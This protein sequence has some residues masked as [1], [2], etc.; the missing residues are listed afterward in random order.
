MAQKG[1]LKVYRARRKLS[2]TSKAEPYGRVKTKKNP[3]LLFVIQKHAAS[4]LHYDFRLEVNG[5]LKSW[6][7]PKG[8]PEKY[9]IRRLAIPTDDH[10]YDYARFEGIIPQGHYGGGTVMVWDIGTYE[11]IKEHQGKPV[12]M[13]QAYAM[14]SVEV[15]LHGK[16]INGAFALVRT[17]MT[18]KESW[19]MLKIKAPRRAK[20]TTAKKIR[21]DVSA[22]TG[23]TLDQIAKDRDAVWE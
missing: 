14:G 23:R 15:F 22:L 1:A 11:N 17:H 4:H 13:E 9:G 8:L 2:K 20:K 7:V 12:S 19:I 3:E 21:K 18:D 5:V 10:P 16:K 6:A